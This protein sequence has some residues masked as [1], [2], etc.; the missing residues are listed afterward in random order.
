M[1]LADGLFPSKNKAPGDA[2][3]G[4]FYTVSLSKFRSWNR[5]ANTQL[6]FCNEKQ[7]IEP[8][9]GSWHPYSFFTA[10]T[11][12][13]SRTEQYSSIN[14]SSTGVTIAPNKLFEAAVQYLRDIVMIS[15]PL[16][17]VHFASA[18]PI[19]YP[20]TR[21]I[22]STVSAYFLPVPPSKNTHP[23]GNSLTHGK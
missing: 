2:W 5:A 6:E 15:T 16:V 17:L 21:K 14:T 12:L 20:F 10:I 11:S 4:Q 22:I 3:F 1:S 23:N 19:G 13:P 18:W 7:C 9:S 8:A